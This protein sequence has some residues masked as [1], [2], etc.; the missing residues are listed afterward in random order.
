MKKSF[1]TR[2]AL[3][4]LM[5]LAFCSPFILRGTRLALQNNRNDVRKWLPDGFQ[6]TEDHAWFET[7]FPHEQ[8]V[9]ASWE[10]CTLD[11]PRL[12]ILARKLETICW[13]GHIPKTRP[14]FKSV[15]T[16]ARLVDEVGAHF[17]NDLSREDVIERLRGTLLG[18]DGR[19][20]CLVATLRETLH[21]EELR[22]AIQCV[23]QAAY[24][25]NITHDPEDKD[26]RL[27]LGG[28]P[29]DNAA[30]DYEG[31]RTLM[32]LAGW[33]L[34][35]GLGVCWFCL[36]SV[37]LTAMVFSCAILAAGIGLALV[38]ATGGLVDAILLSMPSLVY[39]LALSGAIHIINYYHDAIR[40]G[41]L[42]GAVERAIAHAWKPCTVAAVTTAIGLISLCYSNLIP[43]RNFGLYSALGVMATLVLL[44]LVLPACLAMWP[45]RQLAL[46]VAQTRRRNEEVQKNAVVYWWHWI[47]NA[48]IQRNGRGALVCTAM[49]VFF[50]VGATRIETQI[51]LMKLFSPKARILADYAWLEENLGPLVPMEVVI[52]LDRDKCK[53]TFAQRMRLARD[54][55]EAVRS[56]LDAVGGAI[57]AATFAP[58]L[59]DARFDWGDAL[60]GAGER[61]FSK[62]LERRRHRWA[63]YLQVDEET[64][65][66]LWRVSARV[67]ALGDLDY[68]Q[69]VGALREAVEPVC[70]YYRSQGDEGISVTYTGLVP[71]V[72]KA[73]RELLKG[74]FVSLE[75][76]FALIAIVMMI[77]LRSFSVGLLSMIPNLFP[78]V[79]IFGAMGWLG[80]LV[81]V[82]SMMPASVALGV[83]VD[84]TIHYLSWVRHGMDEGYD[85]KSAAMYA[86]ERCATAMTQTTI[87]AGLGLA[88]FALSTF[89]PTERFGYL[90]LTL[91]FAAVFGD[92]VYLPSLLCGPLGWFFDRGGTRRHEVL[93]S[94]TDNPP[95]GDAP[96][97]GDATPRAA[98]LPL[99]R[100]V[101]PHRS[102]R[103]S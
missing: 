23:R 44:F 34:V 99:H 39:V 82:G 91:L 59:G 69:F 78:V 38:S 10:G 27:H 1:F 100:D 95:R 19:R 75:M 15:L 28:P 90:M 96:R 65:E 52:R 46:D 64:N 81:D 97:R 48:I 12:E 7:H 17:E 25:S 50:A 35:I 5:A 22:E 98:T 53:M 13:K 49:M 29:V 85:R 6:E 74:L 87:V 57:S 21:G 42:E 93:E 68:G 31:K 70:R 9:L 71:L 89:T 62:Q 2:Y 33:S 77:V 4:I 47:G 16:G 56:R 45:S 73:Q 3:V 20:T 80:I 66:E 79:V 40:E 18:K 41:G 43:I 101:P 63:E 88:V 36:R 32:R 103:V 55:A 54:V 58:E 72:Y 24:E 30:I 102:A 14:L 92:L 8:F 61:T 84:D 83:A 26:H 67:N 76:A 86:Y 94:A 60:S 11:D 51:K 37:R